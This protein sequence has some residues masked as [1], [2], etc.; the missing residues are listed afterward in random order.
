MQSLLNWETC[1]FYLWCWRFF[2][3]LKVTFSGCVWETCRYDLR[4]DVREPGRWPSFER[5]QGNPTDGHGPTQQCQLQLL[6]ERF[7][8]YTRTTNQNLFATAARLSLVK[9]QLIRSQCGAV[10]LSAESLG[11]FFRLKWKKMAS[12]DQ[13]DVWIF[14]QILA[15]W[16]CPQMELWGYQC[17]P[18]PS[19]GAQEITFQRPRN[20]ITS[21][22][23][24]LVFKKNSAKILFLQCQSWR[25]ET[26]ATVNWQ[27]ACQRCLNLCI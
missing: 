4:Q 26:H 14:C 11:S 23:G 9:M 17:P 12:F 24:H 16:R 6:E 5:K 10:W 7:P 15:G 3:S 19:S 21:L 22:A 20:W 1:K 2:L 25:E 27:K 18:L 8:A 13:W